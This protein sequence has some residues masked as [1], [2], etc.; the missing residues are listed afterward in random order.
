LQSH[1]L[2]GGL[3]L[4]VAHHDLTLGCNVRRLELS[5]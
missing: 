1:V 5:A 3:A 2:N 4:V